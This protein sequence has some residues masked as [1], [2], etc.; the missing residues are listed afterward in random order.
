M[1]LRDLSARRLRPELMD[2]ADLDAREFVGALRG[3]RRVNAATGTLRILFPAISRMARA[4]A[5]APLRVLDVACG[6]GD[7]AIRLSARLRASG[8]A[9]AVHGCDVNPVAV[10]HAHQHA[11]RVKE[12]VSFFSLN[13]IS[14]Q[15]PSGY[16]VIMTSL[17]LHHLTRREA[18]AFLTRAKARSEHLLVHDLL[19]SPV[20]YLL[21]W[22]GMRALLCNRVCRI[23]APRSVAAAFTLEE[24]SALADE[25][26]LD[27]HS[28]EARFPYRFLLQWS[29]G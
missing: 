15:L 13:A 7:V 12:P 22:T 27:G 26:G 2:S 18:C 1:L 16:D 17:F 11:V 14:E 20:G 19:R 6:G 5:D 29:N 10:R 8:I 23:D 25:A 21:A 4:R 28:V 9:A 3:L 24:A